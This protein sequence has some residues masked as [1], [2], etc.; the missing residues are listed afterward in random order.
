MGTPIGWSGMNTAS[1]IV[2]STI[3]LAVLLVLLMIVYI[4]LMG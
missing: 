3:G 2:V 4:P 1:K